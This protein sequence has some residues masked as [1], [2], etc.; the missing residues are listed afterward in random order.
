VIGMRVFVYHAYFP[1]GGTYMSYHL[2]LVARRRLGLPVYAVGDPPQPGMFTYPE[3]FPVVDDAT[4]LREARP[5][6]VLICNPSFSDRLFGLRLP[7][8][9]LC[10]VQ[11]IRTFKVL[12][13]FHDRYVFVSDYAREF[14]H[15]HYGLD[16]PV[17][18]AFIDTGIFQAAGAADVRAR[19]SVCLVMD[20]KRQ[21][22]VLERLCDIY[23]ARFPGSRLPVEVVPVVPQADLAERF[24]KA[25]VSLGL[26]AIEGFYLPMLEAMACGCAVA[27]WESGGGAEYARSGHNALL[28]RYGDFDTLA[29][30]LYG[31]FHDDALATRLAA[32]GIA[33]GPAFSQERF[34]QSWADELARFVASR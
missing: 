17:I 13:V 12:D 34:E 26:S 32:E 15:R 11:G 25:R 5:D 14:V 22:L 20:R 28:A 9:K 10:Y 18:P 8:R 24:R 2:G 21:P 23:A 6:D 3:A 1:A 7:C 4:L 29:G 33:T 19:K 27:G 31:L 16:G 30:H